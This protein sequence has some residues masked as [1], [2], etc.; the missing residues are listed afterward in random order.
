MKLAPGCSL[1]EAKVVAERR[2]RAGPADG[3]GGGIGG[4]ERDRRSLRLAAISATILPHA[5]SVE[6]EVPAPGAGVLPRR[7]RAQHRGRKLEGRRSARAS[8]GRPHRG[9]ALARRPGCPLGSIRGASR[10]AGRRSP[11]APSTS[12]GG[13]RSRSLPRPCRRTSWRPDRPSPGWSACPAGATQADPARAP[14]ARRPQAA[15]FGCGH[16]RADKHVD[17]GV[18]D[19]GLD[20][21]HGLQRRAG[22]GLRRQAAGRRRESSLPVPRT[23]YRP[24]PHGQPAGS[25]G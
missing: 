1:G 5:G 11:G 2:R 19:S 6:R 4:V 22:P 9:E 13:R 10:S 24:D 20:G 23:G 3:S 18:D 25:R 17:V 7:R 14:R 8:R 16:L 21:V 12:R 15:G